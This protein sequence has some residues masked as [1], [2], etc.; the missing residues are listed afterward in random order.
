MIRFDAKVHFLIFIDTCTNRPTV[1]LV[2][3]TVFQVQGSAAG[4]Q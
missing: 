4:L 2:F 1:A 3:A